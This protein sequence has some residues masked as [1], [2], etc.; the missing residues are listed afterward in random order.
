MASVTSSES[1]V[2]TRWV[3]PNVHF[4]LKYNYLHPGTALR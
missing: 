3:F 4:V 1:V 2:Q